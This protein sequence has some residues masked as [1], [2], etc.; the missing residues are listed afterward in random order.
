MSAG[1]EKGVVWGRVKAS[2]EWSQ[3]HGSRFGESIRGGW[4]LGS[5]KNPNC[6][7]SA[8]SLRFAAHHGPRLA[9][10]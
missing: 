8:L 1:E 4:G 5:H 7:I 2:G 9:L 10:W 3:P 6:S